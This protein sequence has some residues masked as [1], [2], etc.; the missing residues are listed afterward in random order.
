MPRLGLPINVSFAGENV[1]DSVDASGPSVYVKS[2]DSGPIFRFIEPGDLVVETDEFGRAKPLATGENFI[3]RE[4]AWKT[5]TVVIALPIDGAIEYKAFM[6][7]GDSIV[8]DWSTDRGQ[9]YFDFHGHTKAFGGD[10]LVRYEESEGDER[11]G[12]AVA[13][14]SGEHGW[15]WQNIGNDPT[16]ITLRIA[17][18][19]EKIVRIETENYQ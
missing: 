1:E 7:Q 2:A 11:S 14:F 5:E 4:T 18:F 16:T 9:V 17:G 13:A 3:G 6:E 8:F 15:Y 19:F 10:I 12:M